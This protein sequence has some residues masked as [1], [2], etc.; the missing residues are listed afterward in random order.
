MAG[1]IHRALHSVAVTCASKVGGGKPGRL[2]TTPNRG[3]WKTFPKATNLPRIRFFPTTE[4]DDDSYGRLG[5]ITRLEP[6]DVLPA[7]PAGFE[8]VVHAT[9]GGN[10]G[11]VRDD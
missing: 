11:V 4:S 1:N 7:I 8:S 5:R 9:D 2:G 6:F 10:L 3:P